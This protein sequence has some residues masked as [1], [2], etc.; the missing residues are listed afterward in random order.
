MNEFVSGI[1]TAGNLVAAL[2]FLKFWRRSRDSIFAA[3]AFAF[4]LL[5]IQQTA[6]VLSGISQEDQSWLFLLRLAAFLTI[7][8]AIL[9]KNAK[10]R[11]RR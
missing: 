5:A 4:L 1:I 11:H 8:G 3:L 7:A 9:H 6:L 2:F 10:Q